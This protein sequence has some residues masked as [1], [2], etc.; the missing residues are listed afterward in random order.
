MKNILRSRKTFWLAAAIFSAGR[1]PVAANPTGLTVTTGSATTQSLG[2]QLNVS[3]SQFAVL[4]WHNFDIQNGETTTFLQPNSGSIVFNVIG[5]GN[6]S[7]IFGNLN[8]NGTV[9]LA[10]ANGFYFGPNSMIKV[11]GSF[12]ATTAPPPENLSG[13][14]PW[15]FTGIPPL[16]SIVNYGSIQ[17]GSGKSLF[18]IAE[19]I[20]NHGNLT[21]PSGNVELTGG[22]IV[23]VSESPDGRGLSASVQLPQGS[24]DNFGH[25]T[26]DAGTIALQAE[27][28]NQ[29]GVLQADSISDN[30]G[31]IELVASGQL[32]LGANSQ[33]LAQGDASASGSAGGTVTL[34][35]GNTFSDAAGSQIVTA[36]GVNGG[37]GGNIEVS[38]PNIESLNSA[39]NASANAG[40]KGGE[41]LLDP[42][43]IVLGTT[44]TGTVPANGT[45]DSGS[46]SGTLTLNVNTAFLNKNFA[47][48]VLQATGDITL[49]TGTTWN[50]S[51]STGEDAGQLT[52]Q[53]GGDIIFGNNSRITDA[54]NWLVELDAGYNFANNTITAGI[55]NIY[56]N[57]GLGGASSGTI[58]TAAGN[59]KLQAGLS[60]LAG[61][62]SVFTTG[63]G[64]IFAYAQ[65]GDIDAGTFN[66]GSTA[67]KPTTDYNFTSAGA[68]PNP[69]LGGFSTAAGGD[70]T[71]IAGNNINSTPKVPTK[72]APG[73]SGTYGSGDV[74][75]IAGN[76][77]TGNYTLAEGTGTMLAGV[78]VQGAQATALQQH[79][80]DPST[81]AS[82]LSDLK[83]AVMQSQNPNGSIGSAPVNGNPSTAP[84]TFG[85]ISGSWNAYA[86]DD[87][88]V[89]EVNNPN[90]A[91]NTLQGFLYNYAPDAAAN[92]W[93]GNAIELTGANLGRVTSQNTT[94]IYAPSLSLNAGA[95]GILVDKSIILAPSGEGSLSI[96]TRDGGNLSGAVA[97]GSTVLNGITMSDSGSSDF[98]TFAA[99]HASTPLHLNDPNPVSLD[100]DGSINSFSLTVPTFVNIYVQGNTYNFGFQGQNVS[101]SQTTSIKVNGSITYRGN[102]TTVALTAAELADPLP[103]ALFTA[104]TDPSVTENLRYDATS[105]TLIFVGVMSSADLAFLLAPSIYKLDSHGN[106]VTELVLDSNGNPI[107]DENGNPETQPVT[108]PV[109]LDAS[110]Q[111]LITQL[112][113]TSQ[114]ASLGGQGLALAGPGHF[115]ITASSMDLGVSGGIRVIAPDSAL[116][117]ISPYGADLNVTTT[118]DLTMTATK[119]SNESLDG[120]LNV[121]VGG[122]LDVGNEF[123]TLGDVNAPK[124]IYTTSSGN[125]SVTAVGDVDVNGS[126]IAAY[127]GGNITLESLTGNINAGDGGNGFVSLNALQLDPVTDQLISIPATIPGSGILAT[128]VFGSDATLGNILVEAPNGNISASKGGVLQISFDGTDASQAGCLLLA[129]YE[130][131]DAL[132]INRLTA[133]DI[134][135]LDQTVAAENPAAPFNLVDQS[136]NTVGTFQYSSADRNIDA[137][138]SGVIAQNINVLA[139]GT[140]GGLF[141]GRG[142]QPVQITA[143]STAP[144]DPIIV[145]SSS[146]PN[147]NLGDTQG[148]D[149][150]IISDSGTSGVAAP[151]A[152]PVV[153]AVTA[154]TAATV[155]TKTEDQG[156]ESILNDSKKGKGI[157]L[158]QK[159]SRVTVLLPQK[160]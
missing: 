48:I 119:I 8:A 7:Q 105:G 126:R 56:L 88:S 36:G 43:N 55:G 112:Y 57:A 41:F 98:S 61:S 11:G 65:A 154:D 60:I 38:A 91:F 13:G 76:Q 145:I 130:L 85:L 93:A 46:G 160:N 68:T 122:T 132:G 113:N 157:S 73:A 50:L 83:N 159:V 14:G 21:A 59:I 79:T 140:V 71:L 134:N 101:S 62:G 82:T 44:G 64:S 16:A 124:G 96:I 31:Q 156:D 2:S 110:Q 80:A 28:V 22:D 39:M 125:I 136:G 74:N 26:A 107:L 150:I 121:T 53:A 143:P 17:V 104:S 42:A 77:I 153:E 52:L 114:S 66:G 19:D 1:S 142:T 147:L 15:Q 78:Q 3:V 35:S 155:T 47:N 108:I 129:G 81:Y 133:A 146:T 128:T 4:N 75:I 10:N 12:V 84:V 69:F 51:T 54:N 141:I 138:G 45:V 97:T 120:N 86:S 102:L 103:A 25:I 117:A 23:L 6:P 67:T 87:I 9:I 100:I 151:A 92:F 115:D 135:G 40:S 89:R 131:R 70:V 72:Q 49:N 123:S 34:K 139:T 63:G 5:G 116:E 90:G 27:V 94:P 152:A 99:G 24:V 106:P 118:G 111:A 29:N 144:G 18:L 95:G 127:N 30:N 158:A 20:Q 32:N 149:P 109:T 148:G 37:N 58:T 33:I 137:G